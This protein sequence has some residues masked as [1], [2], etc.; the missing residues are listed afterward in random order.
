MGGGE[1]GHTSGHGIF[2]QY[3]TEHHKEWVQR[4]TRCASPPPPPPLPPLPEPLTPTRAARDPENPPPR[5]SRPERGGETCSASGGRVFLGAASDSVLGPARARDRRQQKSTQIR[6]G[7]S[8]EL[9]HDKGTKT[10]KELRALTAGGA[11]EPENVVKV[12]AAPYQAEAS[13][14]DDIYDMRPLKPPTLRSRLESAS[15]RPQAP[16]KVHH[17]DFGWGAPQQELPVA[18]GQ[19]TAA[20]NQRGTAMSYCSDIHTKHSLINTKEA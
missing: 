9:L 4:E 16:H 10:L 1:L 15:V 3:N 6:R 11:P 14:T 18:H 2:S 13:T 20:V 12:T 7:E 8:I 19:R 17:H 5:G